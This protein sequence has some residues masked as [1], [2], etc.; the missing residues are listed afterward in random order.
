MT[1]YRYYTHRSP[2]RKEEYP[3]RECPNCGEYKYRERV[4][5]EP[6][7][8]N[9][10]FKKTLKIFFLLEELEKEWVTDYYWCSHCKY[11]RDEE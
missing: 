9:I 2:E 5:K 10:G 3:Y 8:K 7:E 6:V 4:K 1:D 11:E